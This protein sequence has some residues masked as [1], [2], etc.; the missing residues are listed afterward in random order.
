[1]NNKLPT[2]K[3]SDFGLTSFV[4]LISRR[5]P[6]PGETKMTFNVF[7]DQLVRTL[8]PTTAYEAVIAENLV[9]IEWELMQHR[10]MRDATLRKVIRTAIG[11]AVVTRHHTSW[12]HQLELS[13]QRWIEAGNHEDDFECEEFDVVTAAEQGD[14]LA[15]RLIDTEANIQTEAEAELGALGM[16]ALQ[17]MAEGYRFSGNNVTHHDDKIQELERRRRQVKADLDAL[18][19]SRPVEGKVIEG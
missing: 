6:I 18:Q 10:R 2:T 13:H 19:N 14:D 15:R 11:K 9:A 8:V 7:H 1:M 3:P 4:D 17:V 5:E 16:D 12:E